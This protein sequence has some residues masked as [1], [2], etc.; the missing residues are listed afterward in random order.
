MHRMP[1]EV[2][3]RVHR[4][5][6]RYGEK[7]V[8]V[9]DFKLEF[10]REN[11]LPEYLFERLVCAVA[12]KMNNLKGEITTKLYRREVTFSFLEHYVFA[13]LHPL[14]I[15]VWSINC[16]ARGE[17]TSQFSLRVFLECALAVL[18]SDGE[19]YDVM[20]GY[21][22]NEEPHVMQYA[23]I[24]TDNSQVQNIWLNDQSFVNTYAKWWGDCPP[25]SPRDPKSTNGNGQLVLLYDE[26]NEF[27]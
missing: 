13:K 15:Q 25:S 4:L 10:T 24:Y 27:S 9:F 26:P 6:Q 11:F 20:L 5:K 23:G 12:A 21:R 8:K 3:R 7:L 22:A 14:H 19:M 2:L 1:T 16:N 17:T 18:A